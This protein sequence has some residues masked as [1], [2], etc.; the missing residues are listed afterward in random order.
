MRLIT[1]LFTLI[2]VVFAH[3]GQVYKWTDE[4]GQTH[5]SQFPPAQ[6]QADK[7]EVNAPSSSKNAAAANEKLQKVRQ[8]LQE[9]AVDRVTESEDEKLAALEEQ[10]MAENCKK[11]KQRLLDLKNNGRIFKTLENGER[12][13]Y[14]EKGR[15]NLIANAQKDVD[16]YCSKK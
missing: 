14:D 6:T 16:K 3:A 5:F 2:F 11:A 15:A 12:E 4:S 7:V 13:W 9:Q 10:R 8:Q 1:L